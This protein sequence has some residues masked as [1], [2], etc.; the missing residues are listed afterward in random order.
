MVP[1]C[2]LSMHERGTTVDKNNSAVFDLGIWPIDWVG[3]KL[4]NQ[5]QLKNGERCS[6]SGFTLDP[7]SVATGH[8]TSLKCGLAGDP[9]PTLSLESDMPVSNPRFSIYWSHEFQQ[10][11]LLY[12]FP[13]SYPY[14]YLIGSPRRSNEPR[15]AEPFAPCRHTASTR[16]PLAVTVR[17]VTL[18]PVIQAG[19]QAASNS[20]VSWLPRPQQWAK[21]WGTRL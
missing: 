12:N 21:S 20:I 14:T 7:E 9:T 6:R 10:V 2:V 1:M 18:V 4:Q 8:R 19:R 5:T 13:G 17:T 16:L 15:H 3:Q 11:I